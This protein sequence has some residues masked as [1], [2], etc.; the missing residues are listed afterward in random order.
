MREWAR[1]PRPADIGRMARLTPSAKTPA[2]VISDGGA[3]AL[4]AAAIASEEAAAMH[5]PEG[6]A[7]SV[8]WPAG[9]G[10]IPTLAVTESVERQAKALS[11]RR[12]DAPVA[13]PLS[14]AAAS[15]SEAETM[16][17]LRA[18]TLA[19]ELGLR[20]VVWPVQG[21]GVTT[22][23]GLRIA[24]ARA[25]RALLVGR[26]ATIDASEHGLPEIVIETPMVDLS[27]VE[28][29]DLI[30]DL[31]APLDLCWFKTGA[32]STTETAKAEKKRWEHALRE[33]RAGV[34][35]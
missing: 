24:A 22:A 3:A 15:G 29:A 35:S 13:K 34:L 28:V 18:A 17:L 23:E 25:D 5:A 1:M 30:Q 14:R 10:A 8:L 2:L 33:S 21:G 12:V 9:G 11:L 32:A 7:A 20:R 6:Q 19:A 27:D 4:V 31:A 26:L 16:L